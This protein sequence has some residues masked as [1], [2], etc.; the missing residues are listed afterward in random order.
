MGIRP[1]SILFSILLSCILVIPFLCKLFFIEPFPE[2]IMPSGHS[3]IHI[4][5]N[6]ITQFKYQCLVYQN[7]D[8]T[9]IALQ[10]LFSGIPYHYFLG[11]KPSPSTNHRFK[12]VNLLLGILTVQTAILQSYNEV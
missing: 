3:K 12:S 6:I 2:I 10:A 11:E 4:N 1:P 7:E 9:E 5:E 8:S